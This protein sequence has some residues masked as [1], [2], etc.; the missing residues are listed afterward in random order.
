MDPAQK[1][2]T[3]AI[4]ILGVLV[5]IAWAPW[6]TEE[7][8]FELVT[9]H[10]GGDTPYDYLGETILVKNVPKSFVKLPFIVLVYFPGEAV[11]IVTFFGWV[12]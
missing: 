3:R 2:R 4:L 1:R 11:Y 8:A 9:N 6:I 5:I 10:L 7:R 12:I